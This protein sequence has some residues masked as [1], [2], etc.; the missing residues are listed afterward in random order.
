MDLCGISEQLE[1]YLDEQLEG[2]HDIG[3]TEKVIH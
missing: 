1:V 2:R 3:S